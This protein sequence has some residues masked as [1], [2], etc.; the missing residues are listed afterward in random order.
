MIL[1]CSVVEALEAA[2]LHPALALN[3]ADKKGTLNFGSDAD[4]LFLTPELDVISTW[5]AGECVYQ[6]DNV[7]N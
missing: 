6:S 5:I 3:I 2:T 4:F 7:L 1:G